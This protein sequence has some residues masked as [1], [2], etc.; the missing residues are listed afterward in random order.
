[1]HDVERRTLNTNRTPL[2]GLAGRLVRTGFR[3]W[4]ALRRARAFHPDGLLLKGEF[5]ALS[6]EDLPWPV[7]PVPVVARMSKAAGLPGWLPDALGLAVRLPSADGGK[8]WDITLT[9]S[10]AGLTGR[11]LPRPARG[12]TTGRYSTLLPYRRGGEL[13]WLTARAETPRRAESSLPA[14]KRLITE[15]PVSFLLETVR[16]NGHRKPCGTL[17]LH[18][19]DEDAE[20]PAFD[21][22]LNHP[23]DCELRPGWLNVLRERA[24]EGSRAGR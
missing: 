2:A 22:M 9:T 6:R 20:G 5:R 8:P 21:P 17:V 4:A 24:Y 10:G 12:W 15:G 1:M 3:G 11:I 23:R 7:G 18:S 16:A 13:V 19:V 14:L